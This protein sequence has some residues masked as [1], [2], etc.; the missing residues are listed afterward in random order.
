MNFNPEKAL[1]HRVI[2]LAG[3]EEALR[4]RAMEDLL[5]AAN[6]TK[7]DF[8][9]ETTAGDV[10]APKDWYAAVSTS[11]FLG[12]K[13][14][15]IVRH[16]LRCSIASLDGTDF[17]KLPP[18]SL[19]IL[20]ADDES[21]AEDRQRTLKTARGNWAKA[22]TKMGG[23]TFSFDPDPKGAVMAVREEVAKLNKKISTPAVNT[24]VEMTGGSLSRAIEELRK[25]DLYLGDQDTIR[26][27]DIREIV[28][29]SREWNV[30]RM[31][32]S[33]F[34][35][36]V[37]ESLRQLRVLIGGQSKAEDAAF[38]RILPTVSRH[39]RLLWQA[40]VCVEAKCSLSSPS[41]QV[42]AMFPSKP[43]LASE[44][45]YRVSALSN[46][47]GRLT[48]KQIEKCFGIVADTDARLKGSLSSFNAMDTLERML[49]D[50]AG[51]VAAPTSSGSHSR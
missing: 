34:N 39:L 43:N 9:L 29:A 27:S 3:D 51:V 21:G 19:L 23:A 45:P 15:H 33:V 50:M 40:R 12:E 20:I 16:L 49:L 48:L 41:P 44:P 35:G 38:S 31:V 32:D 2:F 36:Q 30:Y 46:M 25:L 10:T 6:V 11:P 17:A 8:D 37:P 42:L 24:L 4:R 7:D 47:A 26:E 28:M 1:Q 5:K 22:I 18:T 14:T 13:R